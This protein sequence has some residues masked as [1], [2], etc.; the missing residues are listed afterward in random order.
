MPDY[1]INYSCIKGINASYED[2][3]VSNKRMR[4]IDEYQAAK[5]E[6]GGETGWNREQQHLRS[7]LL[8]G[9]DGRCL[10]VPMALLP[11][12]SLPEEGQER[13]RG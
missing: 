10:N 12:L 11:Q 3:L 5:K 2:K 7:N 13:L 9:V 8:E 1:L 6:A 4:G